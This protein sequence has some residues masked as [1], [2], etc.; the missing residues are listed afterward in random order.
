[1]L[2]A[3]PDH[4]LPPLPDTIFTAAALPPYANAAVESHRPLPLQITP[5]IL[6]IVV[7]IV[8]E[9]SHIVNVVSAPP[10]SLAE[11]WREDTLNQY[12]GASYGKMKNLAI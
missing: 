2:F 10:F 5:I 7:F 6:C 12:D 1:L 3:R 11:D 4:L 9:Q 8:V